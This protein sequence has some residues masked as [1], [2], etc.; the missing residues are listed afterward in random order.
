MRFK[1]LNWNIGGAKF[2]E[3]MTNDK[4]QVTRTLLNKALADIVK[5]HTPDVVTLQEIA[6]YKQPD[7]V[8]IQDMIDDI[9]GYKYFPFTLIDTDYLSSKAKWRKLLR[10][11]DWPPDTYFGQGNAFLVKKDS[12]VFPVW[13]LSGLGQ[14]IP[15]TDRPHFV[16]IVHL[17][18]GLY[19]GDRNTEPRA[20]LVLHFIYDP[21]NRD[22][23]SKPLDIFVVNLHLTTLMM[24]REGVP[25][26][27]SLASRVRLAQLDIVFNGIVSRYNSWRQDGYPE[28]RKEREPEQHENFD[29]HSP[30][31]ILAGDFNFTEESDEYMYIKRRNFIDTVPDIGKVSP[32]GRGSKAKGVKADPTLTL[33]YV[34]A[35]PKFVSFDPVIEET[36]IGQNRV[37]HEHKYR[38]S[39]HYPVLS[40]IDF[41]PW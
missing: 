21:K 19:F 18:S 41:T 6:R 36:G 14:D 13:D 38:A 31:W 27:D 25:Q 15:A 33:D 28:R 9:A 39:D 3:E 8:E 37:M 17:D 5:E 12:P 40:T 23:P 20:A 4:R 35:G 32:Y 29:R 2:L 11:S 7:D 10:G 16:E 34:F 26:I 30:L 1:V 24:E 22:A